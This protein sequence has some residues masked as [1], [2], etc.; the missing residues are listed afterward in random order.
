GFGCLYSQG[1][2]TPPS[3][4]PP[5]GNCFGY[6]PNEWMTF[7]VGITTGPRVDNEFTK[8]RIRLWIAREGKPSE[9]VIDFGPYNLSAGPAS[10]DQKYGKVWLRPYH[11]GKDPAQDHPTA[12]TWYDELIISTQRIPDPGAGSSG[13]APPA[14]SGGASAGAASARSGAGG[15]GA[16]G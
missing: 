8:S 12:Y 6:F 1:L 16:T 4:F 11:T 2:T 13:T 3:Y 7:Q 5:T 10:E 9:L 15:C 14:P